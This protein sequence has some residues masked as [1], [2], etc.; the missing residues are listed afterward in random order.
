MAFLQRHFA[1]PFPFNVIL[2]PLTTT[3][4]FIQV[5]IHSR[6]VQHAW[7]HYCGSIVT[8]NFSVAV[9]PKRTVGRLRVFGFRF[10]FAKREVRC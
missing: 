10:R 4:W 6:L 2:M 5:G 9:V 8:R 1:V 3:E 7:L